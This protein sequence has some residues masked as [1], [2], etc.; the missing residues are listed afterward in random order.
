MRPDR[1]ALAVKPLLVV[2]TERPGGD[3]GGWGLMD[4]TSN[5]FG[6]WHQHV[7]D[8]AA[9]AMKR[10]LDRVTRRSDDFCQMNVHLVIPE[11]CSLT[12]IVSKGAEVGSRSLYLACAPAR[13]EASIQVDNTQ[14]GV[15][16][17][18]TSVYRRSIDDGQLSRDAGF[19]TGLA[20]RVH[21]SIAGLSMMGS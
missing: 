2:K 17:P 5:A 16:S 4:A 6:A 15:G 21:R 18:R 20:P 10:T 11:D 14:T 9:A 8:N 3:P 7:E 19:E 12:Q 13:N 1:V